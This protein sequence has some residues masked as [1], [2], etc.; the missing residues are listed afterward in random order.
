[1]DTGEDRVPVG[2]SACLIGEPVRFDGGHRRDS[3]IVGTLG[4]FFR[5]VPC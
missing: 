4:R 5:L 3:Y 1:M 2:I